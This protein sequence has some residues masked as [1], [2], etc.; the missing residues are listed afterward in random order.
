MVISHTALP[1]SRSAKEEEEQEYKRMLNKNFDKSGDDE[2][3]KLPMDMLARE[4][5]LHDMCNKKD[6]GC[7]TLKCW[8]S[9]YLKVREE[10]PLVFFIVMVHHSVLEYSIILP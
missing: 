6:W 1:A 8:K 2:Q 4:G 5:L 10:M 7:V 9:K 3:F